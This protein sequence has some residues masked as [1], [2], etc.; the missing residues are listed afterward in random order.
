MPGSP[1]ARPSPRIWRV[2]GALLLSALFAAALLAGAFALF[3]AVK[4]PDH[5]TPL[6]VPPALVQRTQAAVTATAE[7]YG[8]PA[9]AVAF[10]DTSIPGVTFC[11]KATRH[12]EIHLGRFALQPY[13]LDHPE[14]VVAVA[15]HEAGHAVQEARDD[16][17]SAA[18]AIGAAFA[19]LWLCLFAWGQGWRSMLGA[20]VVGFVLLAAI[21][22]Q[23]ASPIGMPGA[24]MPLM[25]AAAAVLALDGKGRPARSRLRS[26]LPGIAV[27]DLGREKSG[28]VTFYKADEAPPELQRRLRQAG[29][30]VSVS[31]RSS[32]QLDFGRRGLS[33]LVRASLH[34]F[35]TPE[36]IGR[37]C[38]VLYPGMRGA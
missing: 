28:I 17:G 22:A 37:F 38:D 3:A 31:S 19:A 33:Q 13:F 20:G 5:P 11:D 36:E 15:E 21:L 30:N 27:H 34:C 12:C 7:A 10:E 35:N 23:R 8:I 16:A 9:P 14:A 29:I 26:A 24:L 1:P 18:L 2:L 25:L 32:A 4:L 6:T